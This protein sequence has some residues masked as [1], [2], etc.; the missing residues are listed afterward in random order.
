MTLPPLILTRP[1]AQAQAWAEQLASLGVPTRS[2]PLI[3]TRAISDVQSLARERAAASDWVFFTSPAAVAALFDGGWAW[4]QGLRATCVGPGTAAALRACG[5]PD[6]QLLSPPMDAE[7][8][9]SEHLWPLLQAATDWRGRRMLWLCGEGGRDWL[10]Q[11]LREAGC[12]VE[13]L[14][15]Y[16]RVA[17][18]IAP[19]E[20]QGLLAASALWLFSSSEAIAHLQQL[21]PDT[22]WAG[23]QALATHP[24]IAER[25]AGL[26]M[27][28]EV[29]SP[30][31]EAV[32]SAWQ[33]WAQG[34]AS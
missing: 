13:L 25:A 27:R 16:R 33:R 23:L 5:V 17:P 3:E 28:C 22:R 9:D 1:A 18:S 11:R 14:P 7:Q 29:I 31:A 12:E 26:G 6:T 20:L 34:S 10:I 30:Q 21:A 32:A 24:R 8:F 19:A 15:I 4:P 2:L